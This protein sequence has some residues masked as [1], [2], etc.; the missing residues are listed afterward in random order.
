VRTWRAPERLTADQFGEDHPA[1][2]G[3]LRVRQG[4]MAE[5]GSDGVAPPEN[6]NARSLA[7]PGAAFCSDLSLSRV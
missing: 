4:V 6:T 3:S 1:Y 2:G 7:A 5:S